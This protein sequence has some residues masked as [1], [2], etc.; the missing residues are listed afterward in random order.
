MRDF[1]SKGGWTF[2][3]ALAPDSVARSYGVRYLPTTVVVDGEG[4]IAKTII[5]GQGASASELSKLV[6]DLTR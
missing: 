5:G 6:D 4:R 2:P 3:V 1:L